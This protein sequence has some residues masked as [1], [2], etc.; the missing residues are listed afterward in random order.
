[1]LSGARQLGLGLR[2]HAD[3]PS[4]SGGARLAAEL[5]ATTA[6]HLEHTDAAGIAALKA[7]GVQPVLLP[8]SVY[9]LGSG[10]Y[11]AARA[12]IEAGA[13]RRLPA[14]LQPRP[15]PPPPLTD[16]PLPPLAAE[17]VE[18]AGGAGARRGSPSS[19]RRTST[20]ARRP[21]PR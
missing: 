12:M 11:P 7:A 1:M 19:S 20:P 6:D 3:Q 10:R 4:L 5:N 18:P 17:E 21:R 9:A 15:A 13:A 14:G 16:D 8:G 2:I